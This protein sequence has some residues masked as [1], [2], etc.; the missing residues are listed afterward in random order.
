MP[1]IINENLGP[2]LIGLLAVVLAY[3]AIR[4]NSHIEKARLKFEREKFDAERAERDEWAK[5]RQQQLGKFSALSSELAE[6]ISRQLVDDPHWAAVALEAAKFLPYQDTLFGERAQHF[7][8]E[9]EEL[10]RVFCPMLLARCRNTIETTGREV[11]LAVDAGTTLLPFFKLIGIETVRAVQQ[12]EE[13]PKHFHLVTNS[14]PGVEELMRTG[15]RTQYDRYARLAID[16]CQLLPGVPIP[17]FAA[18]AGQ[19][20][21]DAI[22]RLR[23]RAGGTDHAVVMAIVVGNWVRIRRSTPRCPVPMARGVAH[24]GVKNA[25]IRNADEVFVISPLGKVFVGQSNANVNRALGF[26]QARDVEKEPYAEAT[27]DDDRAPS[28]KLLSTCR[29]PGRI[30][31][32]HS[33]RL[34]DELGAAVGE[35]IDPARFATSPINKLPHYLVPFNHL[36]GYSALEFE[37]EFPH[38]HTRT[39]K[40]FLDMFSVTPTPPMGAG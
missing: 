32:R 14:L 40:E 1:Q 15:R 17:L 25:L 2:V 37:V 18:V 7:K 29:G 34:E 16:D 3:L 20:T 12:G 31:H 23:K 6:G 11:Y 35:D 10:A 5:A 27:I 8:E 38:P 19:E 39:K 36:P 24:L 13:W 9:K 28:V 22:A 26:G 33:N 30:L 21:E 4:L